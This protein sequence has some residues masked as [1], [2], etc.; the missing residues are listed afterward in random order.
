MTLGANKGRDAGD[1]VSDMRQ[2]F[3]SPHVA[4]EKTYSPIDGRTIR[5]AGYARSQKRQ[6]K[7]EGA[8]G[9]ARA[10]ATMAQTI[11]RGVERVRSRFIQ[12]LAAN[13]LAKLPRLLAE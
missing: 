7:I 1:F 3:G 10:T 5:H 2:P 9:W 11:Y 6:K 13:K 12:R 4:R 8:F